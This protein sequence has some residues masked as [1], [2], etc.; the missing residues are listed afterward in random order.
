MKIELYGADVLRQPCKPVEDFGSDNLNSI[1]RM[2]QETLLAADNGKGGAGLAAPQ[3]GI[4]L[5]LI[6]LNPLLFKQKDIVLC[7]PRLLWGVE[8]QEGQE[9]CLSVPRFTE[10]VERYNLIEVEYYTTEG[11]RKQVR[12]GAHQ[13][14]E[15]DDYA[16][17]RQARFVARCIQH[18]IDHLDGK[19][20]VDYLNKD[21]QKKIEKA[22][23]K[24]RV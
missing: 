16:F 9:G 22:M 18:E 6:V 5:R 11:E 13:S 17:D 15:S 21:R 3:V 10:S 14:A 23:R 12:V 20:F 2:M 7:N 1:I 8:P 24:L 19:L 4:S